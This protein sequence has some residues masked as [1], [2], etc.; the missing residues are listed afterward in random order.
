MYKEYAPFNNQHN[1]K[2]DITRCATIKIVLR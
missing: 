1:S 2:D